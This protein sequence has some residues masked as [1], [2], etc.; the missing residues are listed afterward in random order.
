MRGGID[1]SLS[2]NYHFND[3]PRCLGAPEIP[4]S[5]QV[6]LARD[7]SYRFR[8]VRQF[9]G[10]HFFHRRVVPNRDSADYLAE[11]DELQW[12]AGRERQK[13]LLNVPARRRERLGP[14]GRSADTDFLRKDGDQGERYRGRVRVIA[15]LISV[16]AE[17]GVVIT[18]KSVIRV[19]CATG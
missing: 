18:T 12:D 1:S 7:V 9:D 11:V 4:Q 10:I 3:S 19:S 2:A 15:A 6:L 8:V 17:T 13:S 5:L 14:A 16:I